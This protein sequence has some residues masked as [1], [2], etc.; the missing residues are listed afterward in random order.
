MSLAK[1]SWGGK[2]LNYSRP[3]R[4]WSVTSRLGAGKR[5]TF[6]TVYSICNNSLAR[7]WF[8]HYWRKRW[9]ALLIISCYCHFKRLLTLKITTTTSFYTIV[10]TELNRRKCIHLF[11]MSGGSAHLRCWYMYNAGR[12]Q[13]RACYFYLVDVLKIQWREM[14]FGFVFWSCIESRC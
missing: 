13:S 14:I 4:E 12:M 5:Q 1:L 7:K 6:F 2:T 10:T 3:G 11:V 9:N 8:I